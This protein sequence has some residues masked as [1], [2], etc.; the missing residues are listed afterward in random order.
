MFPNRFET[1]GNQ[2]HCKTWASMM[3]LSLLKYANLLHLTNFFQLPHHTPYISFKTELTQR[4]QDGPSIKLG[5]FTDIQAVIP[6]KECGGR[7]EKGATYAAE[8]VAV[9]TALP[10]IFYIDSFEMKYIL[11]HR[12]IGGV[13]LL[14]T[15]ISM[16]YPSGIDIAKIPHQ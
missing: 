7:E 6:E 14:K 9:M 15:N 1:L 10:R 11:L 12:G 8:K 5:S 2:K 16:S 13:E 3:F 4:C